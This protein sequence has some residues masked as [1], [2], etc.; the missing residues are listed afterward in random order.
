MMLWYSVDQLPDGCIINMA[1]LLARKGGFF[2]GKASPIRVILNHLE[3]FLKFLENGQNGQFARAVLDFF[4]A[5]RVSFVEPLC[6]SA[7]R[8]NL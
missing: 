3:G 8:S 4:P 6:D 5:P 2:R 7:Y 1:D